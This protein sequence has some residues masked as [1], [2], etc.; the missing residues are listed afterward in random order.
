[1]ILIICLET[2]DSAVSYFRT[3]KFPS[4]ILV[5]DTQHYRFETYQI[6]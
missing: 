2:L 3:L 5:L 6:L 4:N 1:M